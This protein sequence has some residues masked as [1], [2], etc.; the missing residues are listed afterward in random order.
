ML[1]SRWTAAAAVAALAA[2][3]LIIAVGPPETPA[4]E[5]F[6]LVG[7][8]GG[9]GE[10]RAGPLRFELTGKSVRGLYPGA[11]KQMRI[12]V[13]NPLDFRLSVRKLTARVTS[14]NRRGCSATPKNLE[15][16]A[17]N[18]PLPV[19]VAAVGRT[20]LGGSIPVVM[21]L[22]ATEKC[23]GARFTISISGVGDRMTR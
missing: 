13:E 17:Y 18:G 16:Q 12:A 9:G 8:G 2:A 21:P 3:A 11:V 5:T 15:V 7:G 1:K 19:T 6:V 4:S 23:A 14:S 10:H 22:G 20:E